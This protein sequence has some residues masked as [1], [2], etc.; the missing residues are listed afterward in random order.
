MASL[1][2]NLGHEQVEEHRVGE[3]EHDRGQRL[4]P[5]GREA[6]GVP[7]FLQELP[8]RPAGVRFVIND[9]DLCRRSA[10]YYLRPGAAT[11]GPPPPPCSHPPPAARRSAPATPTALIP[12]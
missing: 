6:H 11:G 2:C 12:C 8:Q 10:L 3:P 5:A 7:D 4:L 9:P 1:D